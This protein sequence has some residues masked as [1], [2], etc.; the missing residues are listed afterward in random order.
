MLYQCLPA[1]TLQSW[2]P[3]MIA[4]QLSTCL[5]V[6]TESS[7]LC[8]VC[9]RCCR[10]CNGPLH[11]LTAER[12]ER[13]TGVIGTGH[14]RSKGIQPAVAGQLPCR[15]RR[16][17]GSGT[18]PAFRVLINSQPTRTLRSLVNSSQQT[19]TAS[20]EL[21]A[22][23]RQQASANPNKTWQIRRSCGR[24]QWTTTKARRAQR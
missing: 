10:W 3:Y 13:Q 18:P 11:V 22:A 2:S 9:G 16:S 24:T 23:L 20:T 17:A 19:R 15:H 12:Q 4:T 5:L 1:P 8:G 6:S 21:Q 14:P 7:L